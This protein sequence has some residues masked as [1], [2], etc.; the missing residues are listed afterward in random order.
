VG[1]FAEEVSAGNL[2][3]AV[4]AVAI[5]VTGYFAF[6]RNSPNKYEMSIVRSTDTLEEE[7][8][9]TI[10][11]NANYTEIFNVNGFYFNLSDYSAPDPA[12][13]F[14]DSAVIS[15]YDNRYESLKGKI[16]ESGFNY[17]ANVSEWDKVHVVYVPPPENESIYAAKVRVLS[18]N[19]TILNEYSASSRYAW[20]GWN[21]VTSSMGWIDTVNPPLTEFPEYQA[22]AIDFEFSNCY[23]VDMTLGYTEVHGNLSGFW[24]TINQTVI[25]DASFK[26]LFICVQAQICVS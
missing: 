2:L 10:E 1:R 18:S 8:A 4:F 6:S 19:G 25:M 23:L 21:Y 24:Y 20:V 11:E 16:I 9:L 26:P 3:V 17:N 7:N 12:A 5:L 22:S 14:I 13:N 15:Y